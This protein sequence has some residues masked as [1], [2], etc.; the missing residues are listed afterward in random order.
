MADGVPSGSRF[1]RT[2]ESIAFASISMASR[3]ID[4]SAKTN[5]VM[6]T[7]Q[8]RKRGNANVEMWKKI[9]TAIGQQQ[10]T[11]DDDNWLAET[12]SNLQEM[13]QIGKTTYR[14]TWQTRTPDSVFA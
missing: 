7:E 10:D 9:V 12:K 6:W 14:K 2:L 11:Y 3:M 5:D 8:F 1:S 4:G 13:K